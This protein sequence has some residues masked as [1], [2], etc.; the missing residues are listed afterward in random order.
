[1]TEDP[2]GYYAGRAGSKISGLVQKLDQFGQ[3]ITLTFQGKAHY[4]TCPTGFMT[5]FMIIATFF[6]VINQLEKIIQTETIALGYVEQLAT[7]DEVALNYT[8][9]DAENMTMALEFQPIGDWVNNVAIT[10]YTIKQNVA[11]MAKFM[12]VTASIYMKNMTRGTSPKRIGYP[13][14]QENFTEIL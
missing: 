3:P 1:M 7:T 11:E 14:L 6:F 4:T 12:D 13:I 5:L 2:L 8:L 10:N 9:S